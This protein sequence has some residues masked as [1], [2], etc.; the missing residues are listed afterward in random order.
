MKFLFFIH[1]CLSLFLSSGIAQNIQAEYSV[2]QTIKLSTE[3]GTTTEQKIL[4]T[5]Y[6]MR[7]N[8]KYIY[9]EKPDYLKIYSDGILKVS[10]STGQAYSIMLGTDSLQSLYYSDYDTLINRYRSDVPIPPDNY[11]NL[12]QP[13]VPGNMEWK[14]FPETKVINGLKCQRATLTV[15]GQYQWN[16]WF[17][18]D[19]PMQSGLWNMKDVPGLI[20]E[21]DNIPLARHYILE[22][23]NMPEALADSIFWPSEFNQPFKQVPAMGKSSQSPR[24]IKSNQ[25]AELFK[26]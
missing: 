19:I 4:R 10:V 18:A 26:Q 8:N 12:L 11:R 22:K 6:L 2:T 25:Q 7:K 9:Y 5:G 13:F 17:Y 23:Y 15:L 1:L 21:A 20:V 16:I 24:Q 3:S 14:F